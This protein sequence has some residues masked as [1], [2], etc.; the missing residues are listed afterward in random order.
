MKKQLNVP[1]GDH[2]FVEDRQPELAD[3][4]GDAFVEMSRKGN[5]RAD[6]RSRRE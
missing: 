3:V 4:A 2:L 5:G 6:A 1:K